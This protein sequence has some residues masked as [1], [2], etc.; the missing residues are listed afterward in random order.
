MEHYSFVVLQITEL[1]VIQKKC[2]WKEVIGTSSC[3]ICKVLDQFMHVVGKKRS[4]MKVMQLY[5]IDDVNTCRKTCLIIQ[6]VYRYFV[7]YLDISFKLKG[8]FYN[9]KFPLFI[10]RIA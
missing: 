6:Y 9:I 5:E 10:Q 7:S 8:P 2:H 1:N 3:L 4:L